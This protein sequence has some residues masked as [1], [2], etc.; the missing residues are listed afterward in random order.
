[1]PHFPTLAFEE[2]THRFRESRMREEMHAARQRRIKAPQ[3]FVLTTR[4]RLEA[5]QPALDAVLDSRVVAD[6]EMQELEI[7][8]ASP[9]AAVQHARLFEAETPRDQ[10]LALVR[11]LESD[12]ALEVGAHQLE[13]FRREILPA[14]V[15]LL[16]GRQVDAIHR[17]EERI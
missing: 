5:L 10:F 14:P 6:V 3:P 4:T 15:K 16:D 7:L 9:I 2:I 8:E 13:E 11:Q 1:M 17:G 12:V